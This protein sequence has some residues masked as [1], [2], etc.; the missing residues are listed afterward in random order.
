M[1]RW[2]KQ[3]RPSEVPPLQGV[4]GGD[5]FF[6]GRRRGPVQGL[7]PLLVAHG[8]LVETLAGQG[9]GRTD[10]GPLEG[11]GRGLAQPRGV[12]RQVHKLAAQ[13]V[14]QAGVPARIQNHQRIAVR[15]PVQVGRPQLSVQPVEPAAEHQDRL[16]PAPSL[17]GPAHRLQDLLDRA[18]P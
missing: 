10:Q 11:M 17:H 9:V 3:L 4:D 8:L 2:G 1:S 7:G 12:G 14:D 5:P 15:G 18:Y 16:A 13:G 6:K